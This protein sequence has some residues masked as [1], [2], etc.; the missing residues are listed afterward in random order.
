MISINCF[1]IFICNF[2]V[3]YILLWFIFID[4]WNRVFYKFLF[5]FGVIYCGVS[6]IVGIVVGFDG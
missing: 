3:R 2:V 6:L 4:W 1:F 5:M